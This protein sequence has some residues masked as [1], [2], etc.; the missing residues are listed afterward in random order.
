MIIRELDEAEDFA[1]AFLI[2]TVNLQEKVWN[3]C[4]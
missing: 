4:H 1:P 2:M 3:L